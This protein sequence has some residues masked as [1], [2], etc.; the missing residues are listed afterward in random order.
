MAENPRNRFGQHRYALQDYGLTFADIDQAF[1]PYIAD[2][3]VM[4]E[5]RGAS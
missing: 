2:N 3:R 5:G 4:L 1:G